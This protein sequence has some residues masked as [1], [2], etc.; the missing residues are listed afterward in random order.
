MPLLVL[1]SLMPAKRI[2]QLNIL[3]GAT[4]ATDDKIVIFDATANET[5]AI[6]RQELGK[7]IAGDLPYTPSG[8]ISATTIPAA[9]A[10]LD[11]EK[12]PID[13][14]LTSIAGLTTAADKMIYTTAADTYAVAD[15][16][17]AGRDLLDDADAAA[18]R[19]T[20]GL[21]IGVNVQGY[22][23][24]ILKSADIGTTV[25]GYDADTAKTDTA[26][27][28]TAQQTLS[29]GLVL[30]IVAAVDIAAIAN[31]INT[32]N[33]VAG[34]VIYDSTNHRLMIADGPLDSDPWY[35]ADGSAFVTPS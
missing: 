1:E 35:V 6:T 12:Q 4:S 29:S 19:I 10:E 21:E 17:S 32:A 28:F 20:L 23:A 30:Q 26:Q 34:K 16:T 15:L 33:K 11:S 14:G 24:T 31:A 22:D 27:T 7:G 8:G 9:I 3:T 13:A 18:Q 5:K 25:Q 2:P